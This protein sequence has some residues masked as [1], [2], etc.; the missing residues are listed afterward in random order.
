[1]QS[2]KGISTEVIIPNIPNKQEVKARLQKEIEDKL[3]LSFISFTTEVVRQ[4]HLQG[5]AEVQVPDSLVNNNNLIT[6]FQDKLYA[7]GWSVDY[8]SAGFYKT[9]MNVR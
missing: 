3:N 7:E 6:C 9:Y 2:N 1:M 4:L 8:T 5:F